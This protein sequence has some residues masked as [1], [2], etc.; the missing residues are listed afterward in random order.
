M[1]IAISTG[2]WRTLS[3]DLVPCN[4][5]GCDWRMGTVDD[6]TAVVDL[7]VDWFWVCRCVCGCV[8]RAVA[9]L[10]LADRKRG[11]ASHSSRMGSTAWVKC[12]RENNL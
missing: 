12:S 1:I 9:W 3:H 2:G 7:E 11:R 5:S 4:S 10:R 8:W 6:T